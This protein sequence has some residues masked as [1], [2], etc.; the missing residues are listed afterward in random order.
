M[1]KD[2]RWPSSNFI[3]KHILSSRSLPQ[4]QCYNMV[5][6]GEPPGPRI[7][8]DV[9]RKWLHQEKDQPFFMNHHE[10]LS[11]H[12]YPG[13]EKTNRTESL[14]WG[15][16]SFPHVFSGCYPGHHLSSAFSMIPE[17]VLHS[18]KKHRPPNFLRCKKSF[19]RPKCGGKGGSI[20]SHE[21]TNSV[22]RL[23]NIFE[24]WSHASLRVTPYLSC[25]VVMPILNLPCGNK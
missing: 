22:P 21:V 1:A 8:Q 2:F 16:L 10:S 7:T 15:G 4:Y 11:N 13:R 18:K 3:G 6:W 9:P 19:C 5:S 20:H 12:E 17:K 14:P 24:A 23:G 25:G